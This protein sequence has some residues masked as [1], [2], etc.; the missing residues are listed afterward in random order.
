MATGIV[1]GEQLGEDALLADS[2]QSEPFPL[3]Q[4]T[5][6]FELSYSNKLSEEEIFSEVSHDY[7][8]IELS[9]RAKIINRISANAFLLADNFYGLK[10]LTED[11]TR[12]ISLI[13]I[14]PPYGTG[15]K[16]CG[17][18]K[19]TFDFIVDAD[20][21]KNHPDQIKLLASI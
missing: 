13:Y 3:P 10:K 20:V 11:H 1:K 2:A 14:D 8:K 12:K 21:F 4:N 6:K 19:A 5:E 15:T 9:G 16:P 18:K 7:S 17:S